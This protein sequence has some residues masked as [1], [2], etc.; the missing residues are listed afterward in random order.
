MEKSYNL[1]LSGEN[2]KKIDPNTSLSES[3]DVRYE[4]GGSYHVQGIQV[5]YKNGLERVLM[6]VV[7]SVGSEVIMDSTQLC[8]IGNR[9]D[10][11]IPRDELPVDF[12]MNTGTRLQ[13]LLATDPE[14]IN[15]KDIT[16]SLF[17]NKKTAK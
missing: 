2:P 8:Q 15:P 4:M 7:N 12:H 1:V 5:R 3:F 6:R 13:I 11:A 14:T 9:Q 17:G 16:V 10:A